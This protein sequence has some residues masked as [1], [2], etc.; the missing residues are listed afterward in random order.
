MKH[1]SEAIVKHIL[2][3]NETFI[4]AIVKYN[5][6]IVITHSKRYVKPILNYNETVFCRRIQNVEIYESYTPLRR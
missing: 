1:S 2:N 3:N 5:E 4:R 6:A